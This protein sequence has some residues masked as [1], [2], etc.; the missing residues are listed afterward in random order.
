MVKQ[1]Q[2]GYLSVQHGEMTIHGRY[3]VRKGLFLKIYQVP[4]V[5][6]CQND[7]CRRARENEDQ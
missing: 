5:D 7:I 2:K 4:G 6:A 1:Y 3:L